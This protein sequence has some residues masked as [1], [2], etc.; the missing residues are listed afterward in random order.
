MVDRL[1]AE[2]RNLAAGKPSGWGELDDDSEITFN[3]GEFIIVAARTGHEKT[4]FV[5]NLLANLLQGHPDEVF[6]LY[7]AEEPEVATYHR[8]LA[9]LSVEMGS[10]WT[11]PEI[12]SF[13]RG[14]NARSFW[15]SPQVL[16]DARER[17]RSLG[18]GGSSFPTV[19]AGMLRDSKPT[20]GCSLIARSWGPFSWTI[21]NESP[22]PRAPTTRV[23]TL[24]CRQ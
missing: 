10:L 22:R 5:V 9:L 18:K 4:S 11:T 8:L 19:R 14:G 3:S 21:C 20:R 2:S 6:V 17:L 16:R 1:D 13:L 15:P 23:A 12:R 24:K 7:S